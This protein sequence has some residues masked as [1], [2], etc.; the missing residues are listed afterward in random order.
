[1]KKRNRATLYSLRAK[2]QIDSFQV[3]RSFVV[4]VILKHPGLVGFWD[5][6]AL[7]LYYYNKHKGEV[8]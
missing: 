1:M 3:Q 2:K 7:L 4:C 5:F 8:L 6:I